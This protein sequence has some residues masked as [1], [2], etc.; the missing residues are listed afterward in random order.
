ANVR[1]GRLD[2]SLAFAALARRAD[3]GGAGLLALPSR[4][5]RLAAAR[6][7]HGRCRLRSVYGRAPWPLVAHGAPE[8]VQEAASLAPL[9]RQARRTAFCQLCALGRSRLRDSRLW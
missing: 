4:E 1:A 9:G 2:R 7:R 6:P 8:R 3:D 5:G